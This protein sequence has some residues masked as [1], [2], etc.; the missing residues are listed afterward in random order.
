MATIVH[1]KLRSMP[2]N[3]RFGRIDLDAEGRA[4]V[5]EG[6]AK[7]LVELYGDAFKLAANGRVPGT[8]AEP[9][10]VPDL[11]RVL[12]MEE[13]KA[14]RAAKPAKGKKAQGK[15]AKKAG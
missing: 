4:T 11:R 1:T 12:D 9:E 13:E 6:V 14:V 15:K 2:V 3:T 5:E 7:Q 10:I 8:S